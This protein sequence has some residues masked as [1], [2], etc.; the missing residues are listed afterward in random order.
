MNQERKTLGEIVDDI[1]RERANRDAAEQSVAQENRRTMDD[2]YKALRDRLRE[3]L[4]QELDNKFDCVVMLTL[5]GT[6]YG[7]V[8]TINRKGVTFVVCIQWVETEFRGSDQSPVQKYDVLSIRLG[9]TVNGPDP[10]VYA[11]EP[12]LHGGV[13][14]I[15]LF[16]ERLAQW[17]VSGA[18]VGSKFIGYN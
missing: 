16:R 11:E 8:A 9:R 1:N 17:V 4:L 14:V 2:K 10:D 7:S 12:L 6:G 13:D 3:F 18:A 5:D 15:D